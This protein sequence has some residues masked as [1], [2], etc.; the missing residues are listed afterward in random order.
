MATANVKITNGWAGG[1]SIPTHTSFCHWAAPEYS[2]TVQT[3]L[4]TILAVISFA[5]GIWSAYEQ[6]RIFKLRY[7]IAKGY[8]NIAKDEWNRF[9]DKYRPLE[10]LMIAEALAA[11]AV[12]PDYATAKSNYTQFTSAGYTQTQLEMTALAKKFCICSNLEPT[13]EKA[14]WLDDSINYGYRDE[15]REAIVQDDLRFNKRANLLNVGRNNMAN[16]AK[17]GGLASDLLSDA[18]AANEKATSGAFNFL[19]YVRNRFETTY[20]GY[21]MYSPSAGVSMV[22]GAGFNTSPAPSIF[23]F[24]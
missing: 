20:P 21:V 4:H 6:L 1:D 15:E 19:G 8:A 22:G 7:E 23:S 5:V 12:A 2:T 3:L 11:P 16:S 13:T 18:A 14:L 17:Y 9:N 10:N 24:G